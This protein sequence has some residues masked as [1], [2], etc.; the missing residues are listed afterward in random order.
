[1]RFRVKSNQNITSQCQ[2]KSIFHL[3]LASEEQS[4][5]YQA[6]D[7]LTVQASNQVE[8]VDEILNQLSLTGDEL[9][10]LRRVGSVS[11]REALTHHLEISQLNPAIFNKLQRQH[12]IG[13]WPDRQAMMD[14]AYG[15]DILDLLNRFPELKRWGVEFLTL[16]AP[17][18]PRYYS[19]ASSPIAV[20]NEVHLVAKQVEYV[21]KHSQRLHQGVA[22][23]AVSLLKVGD[24]VEGDIKSN[25]T[26][27]LPENAKTPII[28]IGAGTGIAPFI[29]F[30]QQRLAENKEGKNLLFF[31]E[32]QQACSFLFEDFLQD[33]VQQQKLDL[34][35]AFSRDQTEKIYVQD[36]MQQL[37]ENVWQQIQQGAYIYICGSQHGLA[38]GVEKFWIDLIVQ[39]Q[40]VDV[41]TAKQVWQRWRKEKR[42][43]LD[44]Y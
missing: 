12:Q 44:V 18:G 4:L 16:L 32:T 41:D 20:G 37:A 23:T 26:F 3:V 1:M 14:E 24:E 17:L 6:G 43:Q 11:S 34:F 8:W 5:N 27:K 25:P 19:I 39:F 36:R 31:G 35:T 40:N 29:G 9:I 38:Q 10:E 13:N 42:V 2:D 21:G 7:W 15:Q 22:S 33:C 30:L 28:M